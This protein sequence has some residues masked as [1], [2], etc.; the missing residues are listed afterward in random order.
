MVTQW[1]GGGDRSQRRRD[2]STETTRRCQFETL[3]P[4]QVLSVN[5]VVAGITYHE[6][7]VGHDLGPDRFEVTFQGG[8]GTTQLT[9]FTI[10]GDQDG[11]GV[12]SRGDIVFHANSSISGAGA[13]HPFQFDAANSLG[14][15]ADDIESVVVSADGLSLTVNVRNFQ[16]GDRLVFWIDV[17]E[18]ETLRFDEIA[19]GVEFEGNQFS[20]TFADPHYNFVNRSITATAVF[21]N[22]TQTQSSGMFYDW[23]D[24]LLAAGGQAAG[25]TLQLWADNLDGMGNRSAAAITAYDLVAKPITISGHVYHD[26]NMNLQADPGESGIGNVLL[27]LQRWNDTE[28]RFDSI[29][30]RTTDASGYYEFG[31]DLNLTPG[32]YRIVQAQ[33][34]GFLSVG[35]VPGTV[36]GSTTGS[37]AHDSNSQPN[38]LTNIHVS[39]GGTHGLN[40]DFFEIKPVSIT[41]T[42]HAN[43]DGNCTYNPEVGDYYLSGVTLRLFDLQ[44]NQVAVTQTDALGRY[45]FAGMLPGT[46]TVV[47]DQP[48]GLLDGGA[49][50]GTVNGA[51]R[52]TSAANRISDISLS[53][54]QQGINY[55]FC[56]HVPA[57]ICGY[58]YHDRNNDGVR[59]PGEEGI[60]NV[61]I[62]LF[63]A[64]GRLISETTTNAEGRYCFTDL[65][66][67]TYRLREV[68]PA[69]FVDG[70]DTVGTIDGSPVGEIGGNDYFRN[71]HV[72]GGQAAV[73]FNF[74]ELRL[75][76]L[77]GF[78]Y[79]DADGNQVLDTSRGDQPIAGVTLQLLDSSGQV[80]ATTTT[81]QHGAYQFNNLLPGTYSVRQIQPQ[82][83]FTAG[84]TVGR[85]ENGNAGPGSA[86]TTNLLSGIVIH[87]GQKLVQYD[88]Q[89]ALPAAIVGRV[90]EDGPAFQ[91]ADGNVPSNYRDQRD[92]VYQAG[93]DTPL[94]GVRMMLYFFIDPSSGDIAPRPVTLGDVLPG[95]YGHLGTSD[96]QTPIWV[97]TDANGEYRFEG[98]PAGNYIVVQHQPQGYTDANDYA[99]TTT[100]FTYNSLSQAQLAPASVLQTF[101]VA[102]VMDSIVNIRI[103]AG[104]ISLQNNFTEVRA[105]L[106][107]PPVDPPVNPPINP[108][109]PP[110]T[111]PRVPNPT[112]PSPPLAFYG[113]L[114]GAQPIQSFGIVQRSAHFRVAGQSDPHTWHLSVINAGAPRSVEEDHSSRAQWL[115]ASH[116]NHNDWNR[117]NM[118]ESQW[119]FANVVN[120]HAKVINDTIRF[121]PIDATPLAGDF[122]GDGKFEIAIYKDGYFLIDI[123][124]NG[125]W[126]QDDLLVQL[127]DGRDQP[128]VGDWDGDG[129]DDVGIFG[130]IWAGDW[131]AI[132]REPGLPN[133]ENVAY[134]R[135][136]NVPPAAL[137]GAHGA[138]Y[139]KLS[140]HG[141]ERAD[142]IDHVFGIENSRIVPVT[143]DWNGNGIRSIGAF[144]GGS[145]RLDVNGDGLYDQRDIVAQFGRAGDVPI[146]GDFNGDG[147]DQIGIYRQGTWIIDSNYNYQID[148]DDVSFVF[149]SANEVPVVGDWNGDGRAGVGLFRAR[150]N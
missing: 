33:P 145:W 57:Q 44:G 80:V 92:G 67:G 75:A 139:L 95:N 7:D 27:T 47:Q 126:D 131:E 111:P 13:A 6:L 142:L 150:T 81:D 121:G 49:H 129:K 133:P 21:E 42:V 2:I 43:V 26:L 23:Y 12:V 104:G 119:L 1:L 99:G 134:T 56:E 76:S 60:A 113:G 89:E 14:I 31:L 30:Q 69:N 103:N 91:T 109:T 5:P 55:N 105:E 51:P 45:T 65:I 107:Q 128:V 11:N 54:G 36:A 118:E 144:E 135:P 52:G 73:N 82:D 123:N 20:A 141:K 138:R 46:Y 137:E 115:Q 83:Y 140:A 4:R 48:S 79:Y 10:N 50:V 62:R 78:V 61:V 110:I 16:A 8:S 147:I 37:V 108:L 90:W 84:Q 98:L 86:V 101:S 40:Y 102:Q 120:G 117:F 19:S 24:N 70:R 72:K 77:S 130:P 22:F 132:A 63:D 114:A 93:V 116:L 96:P 38:I 32:T 41:G 17:D 74:G 146:V 136:K 9:S 68:Q 125:S 3:E 124:G 29:A 143:G 112:P 149:G 15:T 53:S 35:A 66:A 59:G 94:A 18:F 122:T 34:N 148:N 100:G 71:I 25:Q 88:F 85:Y 28:S 39:L 64:D 58:V 87:S 127:G 106:Y 97:L